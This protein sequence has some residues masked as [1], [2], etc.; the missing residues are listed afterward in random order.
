MWSCGARGDGCGGR[1]GRD[2]GCWWTLLLWLDLHVP[3][4][5]IVF[6]MC[7]HLLLAEQR[8]Q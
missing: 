5:Q 4:F 6:P 2:E 1:R 3:T 7:G 8:P